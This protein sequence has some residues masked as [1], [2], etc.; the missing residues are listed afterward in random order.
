MRITSLL[1]MCVAGLGGVASGG[2][3]EVKGV[4]LCCGS[5]VTGVEKALKGVDGVAG[6]TCDRA[7]KTVVFTADD[8]DAAAAGIEALA[9]G[10]FHGTA[11]H[12]EDAVEF[13]D[14]GAKHDAK[15]NAI[16]LTHVH[17][18]CAACVKAVKA[19]VGDV[20]GV[21]DTEC[22]RKESTVAITG[23]NVSVE[24]VVEA[25]NEAG[26]NATVAD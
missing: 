7:E 23:E 11:T 1:L 26:F 13:P 6:V 5:C 14:S 10:G 22:D 19:A 24:A 4:H 9:K 12:G 16:K 3:V 8:D 21:N 15:A 18:C 25:L 2:E 20:D 17:L